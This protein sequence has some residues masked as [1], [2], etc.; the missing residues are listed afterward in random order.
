VEAVRHGAP[1]LAEA[2]IALAR[3][4]ARIAGTE[5]AIELALQ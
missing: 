2:F 1:D 4:A 5:E 3:A